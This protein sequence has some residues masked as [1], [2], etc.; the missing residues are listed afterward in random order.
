MLKHVFPE[1]NEILCCVSFAVCVPYSTL[2]RLSGHC[3]GRVRAP[4]VG[5]NI[6]DE[7]NN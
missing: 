1:F 5:H 4:G 3:A 7:V 2:S 6:G